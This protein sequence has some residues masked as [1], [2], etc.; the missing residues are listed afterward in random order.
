MQNIIAMQ[1]QWVIRVIMLQQVRTAPWLHNSPI[2][3]IIIILRTLG[4]SKIAPPVEPKSQISDLGT[5][6]PEISLIG[7]V[8]RAIDL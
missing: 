4:C 1:K 5:S 6:E 8:T 3:V 2:L 7:S